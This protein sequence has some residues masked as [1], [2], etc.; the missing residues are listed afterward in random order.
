ML[1]DIRGVHRVTLY[2]Q[3]ETEFRERKAKTHRGAKEGL[4][5][6]TPKRCKLI[7]RERFCGAL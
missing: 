6:G 1:V 5:N 3:L 4:K 7:L 2:T